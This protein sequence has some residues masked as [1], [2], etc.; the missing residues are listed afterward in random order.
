M[1]NASA[2]AVYPD[3]VLAPSPPD[4]VEDVTPPREDRTRDLAK[5]HLTLPMVI[6]V[7]ASALSVTGGQYIVQS[8]QR[9]AQADMQSDI[10]DMRTRMEYEAK[11][12]EKDSILLEQRFQALEAK[13][14]TAGLRNAAI[15]MSGELQ[16]QQQKQQQ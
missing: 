2:V 14:E 3:D 1:R 13:I 8:G 10:R 5:S 11:L 7:V 15:S 4:G 9:Q 6:A 16:K 12:N